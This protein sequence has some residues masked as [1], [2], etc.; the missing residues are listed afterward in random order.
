MY[1]MYTIKFFKAQNFFLFEFLIFCLVLLSFKTK[2][3]ILHVTSNFRQFFIEHTS[4]ENVSF[5]N[6]SFLIEPKGFQA[7]I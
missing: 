7:L 1:F 6:G 5:D 3:P 2:L 4:G